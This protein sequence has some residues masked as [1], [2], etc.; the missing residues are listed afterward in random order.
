MNL[1]TRTRT[2]NTE[3]NLA[4]IPKDKTQHNYTFDLP[5]ATAISQETVRD[6]Q[7]EAQGTLN[8]ALNIPRI[9]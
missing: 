5:T 6:S 3:T 8:H 9:I 2:Y 7:N 1:F 4:L